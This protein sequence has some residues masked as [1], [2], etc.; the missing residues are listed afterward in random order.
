MKSDLKLDADIKEWVANREREIREEACYAAV[1]SSLARTI[2]YV[3]CP[4][5]QRRWAA[6]PGEP[7]G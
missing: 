4:H 5:C 3:V 1:S 7:S 6:A 2:D